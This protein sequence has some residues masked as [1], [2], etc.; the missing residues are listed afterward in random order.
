MVFLRLIALIFLTCYGYSMGQ[1]SGSE[2]NGFG[3]LAALSFFAFAPTLYFLP[4][5]E[6][7]INKN[8]DL[9]RVGLVNLF[10]GWSL[11]GWVVAL[12]WALKK[13][14]SQIQQPEIYRAVGNNEIAEEKLKTCPDCAESV[15]TAARLC[16]HCKHEFFP[17]PRQL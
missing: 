17:L 5:I 6:A 9:Q 10:L 13:N 16:K 2:L 11:V 15:L 8:Q 4:T 12:V 7:W 14:Q 3:R 1:F